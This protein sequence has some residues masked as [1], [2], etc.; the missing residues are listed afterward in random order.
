MFD[1]PACAGVSG[2]LCVRE[3]QGDIGFAAFPP[4]AAS[5]EASPWNVCG[6]RYACRPGGGHTQQPA[7]RWPRST[8]SITRHRLARRCCKL[9]GCITPFSRTRLPELPGSAREPLPARGRRLLQY[10]GTRGQWHVRPT[11]RGGHTTHRLVGIHR[12][13]AGDGMVAWLAALHAP[14]DNCSVLGSSPAT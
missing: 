11:H 14:P 10:C 6:V 1:S 2:T 4:H 7:T 9:R 12:R 3:G 5:I 8:R 13:A